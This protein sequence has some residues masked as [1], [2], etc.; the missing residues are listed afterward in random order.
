M[1]VV[2]LAGGKGTRMGEL[3]GQ[4]PKPMIPIAGKPILQ[5]QIELARRFQCTEIL[6]LTG[7]LGETIEDHFGD[8]SDWGVHIQYHREDRPLGTAGALRE[9]EDRLADDFLVFYGDIVMDVD[10]DALGAFHAERR[11]LA[12]LVVHP[13]N[14]P[15]DSDLLE[16][17]EEGRVVAFHPKPHDPQRYYRNLVNAALYV[18]S[19]DILRQIP[20]GR[21]AD[22]GRDVFPKLVSDGR[23]L[24]GYSTPEYIT[25]VGTPERLAEVGI[26]VRCGKV[27]RLN[28]RNRRRAIFLDRD[29]VL[30]IERDHLTR[31]EQLELL[32]GA[33]EAV[34][35][36]NRS[37]YLAVVVS[38]QPA[39]AKGFTS[40]QEL[41]RIHARLETLLGAQR[42]YLDRIYYCPHHPEKGF[43]GERPE[44]KIACECRKP[45]PGMILRAAAEL[46]VDLKGSLMIGDR[47]AD[48]LAGRRA[49]LKTIL[50]RTG[51]GGNDDK[52]PCR[53]DFTFDDLLQAADFV[54]HRHG[55]P[56]DTAQ[57]HLSKG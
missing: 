44:Y 19:P 46:N 38:N 9:V 29:G 47:T 55:R 51:Y 42:A 57:P 17:D 45:A 48:I 16:I 32:P 31:A 6:L 53:P 34:R 30:N 43:P 7:H 56:A 37:E 50:V 26:D 33:A 40:Q 13:N 1:Q 18:L 28:R 5:Y 25:D 20:K 11:P 14:H 35:L 39:I 23:P 8:G 10:L 36:I 15:Y 54:I 27:A 52:Y 41:D 49:G 3:A 4:L 22:L 21:F 24:L 2:I 12:T